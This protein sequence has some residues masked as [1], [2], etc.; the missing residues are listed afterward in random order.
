MQFY[1][2]MNTAYP[3]ETMGIE[4]ALKQIFGRVFLSMNGNTVSV[5]VY[6][7]ISILF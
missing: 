1:V 5:R 2:Y 4:P 3:T 6:A 7:D